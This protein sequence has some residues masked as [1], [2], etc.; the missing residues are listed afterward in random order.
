MLALYL[1]YLD[2]DNDQK[3]FEDTAV[4]S[5]MRKSARITSLRL[6]NISILKS[7]LTAKW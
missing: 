2:D 1:A 7:K 5:S 4:I 6:M 3:L